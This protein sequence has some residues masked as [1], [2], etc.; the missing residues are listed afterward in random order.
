ML[1]YWRFRAA[2]RNYLQALACTFLS[3]CCVSSTRGIEIADNSTQLL[4]GRKA[5]WKISFRSHCIMISMRMPRLLLQVREKSGISSPSSPAS[6]L[7]T[8][9][10]LLF[11]SQLPSS[12]YSWI[13]IQIARN[14][15][16][17]GEFFYHIYFKV[18]FFY[19]NLLGFFL[20]KKLDSFLL[21]FQTFLIF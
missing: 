21:N 10:Q 19:T 14:E 12:V 17:G 5:L 3:S 15:G 1:S 8:S 18:F 4:Y 6:N 13:W 11:L 20:K 7:R 9:H 16:G 2:Q